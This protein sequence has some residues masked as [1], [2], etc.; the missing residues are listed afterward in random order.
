MFRIIS[1]PRGESYLAL[2]RLASRHCGTFSLVLKRPG[3]GRGP[4]AKQMES[5]LSAFS[6]GEQ[7]TV[8]WG[9]TSRPLGS[10]PARL[11]VYRLCDDSLR[12]LEEVDGLFAWCLPHLP[13]DLILY[14]PDGR[15]FIGSTAHEMV[16]MLAAAEITEEEFRAVAPDVDY[17]WH[18]GE[19]QAR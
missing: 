1:E 11:G 8:S 14:R 17:Q 19:W 15:M 2:L 5:R 10:A 18:P 3:I 12:I 7:R 6:V 9:G 13:E 4:S 16:A